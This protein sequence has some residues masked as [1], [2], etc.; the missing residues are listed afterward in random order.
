MKERL[1]LSSLSSPEIVSNKDIK[2]SRSELCGLPYQQLSG[3][4][5]QCIQDLHQHHDAVMHSI[6]SLLSLPPAASLVS[7]DRHVGHEFP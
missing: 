5:D 6:E 4:T 2:D 1:D 3:L 7:H